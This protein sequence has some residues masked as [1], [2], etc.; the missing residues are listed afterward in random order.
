[1]WKAEIKEKL[2]SPLSPL[3]TSKQLSVVKIKSQVYN[4]SFCF[5]FILSRSVRRWLFSGM[6]ALYLLVYCFLIGDHIA[7]N[8]NAI[9]PL[10]S[11]YLVILSHHAWSEWWPHF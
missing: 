11:G 7:S 3:Y 8:I 5:A 2:L 4:T 10:V 6:S 9:F 1:M